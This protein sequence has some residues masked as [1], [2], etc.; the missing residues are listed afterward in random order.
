MVTEKVLKHT[1]KN[2]VE[3]GNPNAKVIV[4]KVLAAEP[5]L[6]K[7][8]KAVAGE[9]ERAIAKISGWDERKKRKTLLGIW[10]DALKKKEIEV[11]EALKPLPNVG[12]KVVMRFAPNPNGPPTL[13]SSRG[14][15]ING[16]YSKRY[17]GKLICRF[18]DTDPSLKKPLK[19]AYDWYLEDMEWLGYPP[20]KVV[21]ASD[22]IKDYYRVAEELIM[23]RHAYVCTCPAEKFRKLKAK[24]EACPCRNQGNREAMGLWKKMLAGE[25]KEGEAV[26]RI[27]TDMQH[28]DPAMRDWVAFRVRYGDHTRVGKEYCVWP[29]LDFEGA[30]EDHM[31]GTTHIIRGKDLRDSTGRQKYLYGYMGWK[32]PETLY[33]GRVA[34]HEFGKLST[35]GIRKGIEGGKYN[36][37]DDPR[38][39]TIRALRRRGFQAEAIVEFWKSLGLTEKDVRASMETIAAFNKRIID[40]KAGRYFFV[41]KPKRIKVGGIPPT[42]VKLHRHP[43]E[44]KGTREYFFGGEQLFY[45]PETPEE[46]RLKDAFNVKKVGR[47]KY[48]YAGRELTSGPKIQWVSEPLDAELVTPDK[49]IRGVAERYVLEAKKGQIV[50]L[51]RVGYARIDG[52]S[53]EKVV[54]WL[55]H[56]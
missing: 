22:R 3:H 6:R 37:W 18:D 54:F 1:L 45:V 23:K 8:A 38:L 36:G 42:R 10:P 39:P 5:E 26:L 14:I 13:G 21:Y 9:V 16:E 12:K 33:W 41:P 34:V 47:G 44:E 35:S 40:P 29:M 20:D 11:K 4:G 48:A 50:Q 55:T 7:D 51:E 52:I 56:L 19:E 53:G 46:F 49:K 30:V 24:G 32:Y 17:N 28:K 25:F 15:V 27:K 43:G 31:L 2:A